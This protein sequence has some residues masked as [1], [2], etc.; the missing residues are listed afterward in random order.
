MTKNY[1]QK[2]VDDQKLFSEK[3]FRH[4]FIFE[5]SELI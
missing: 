4:K 3:M 2:K 1:F 5:N